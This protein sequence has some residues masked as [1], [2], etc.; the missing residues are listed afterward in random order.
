MITLDK[1]RV[2]AKAKFSDKSK[3]GSW[4]TDRLELCSG[5]PYNSA[6]KA[7]LSIKDLAIV[8]VNLGKP[9]CLGCGCEIEAKASVRASVCGLQDLGLEPVWHALPEI[10]SADISRIRVENY[11]AD[12]VKLRLGQTHS[13]IYGTI[14]YGSDTAITISLQGLDYK[15]S[16]L[17]I[18]VSCGCTSGVAKEVGGK[19]YVTLKYDSTRLGDFRKSVTIRFNQEGI[20]KSLSFKLEGTVIR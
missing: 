5:C 2:I 13:L 11:S 7:E 8:A 20:T 17:N 18:T 19:F 10:D 14:K 15:I 16:D 6:N 4:Y 3:L 9:A 12:K 1:L